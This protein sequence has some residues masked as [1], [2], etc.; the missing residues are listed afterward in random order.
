MNT[1]SI[2][3]DD[4]RRERV[5]SKPRLNGLDYLD[6]SDDQL[7]L[8]VYFL[9]KA[10]QHL[11]K[12]NVRISGGRRIDDIKVL[13]VDVERNEN[14]DQDDVMRVRLDKSG[15]FS[16]Y[17]LWLEHTHAYQPI[18][19][20]Y[21]HIDFSF[22]IDCPSDL[23][24]AAPTP[25]PPAVF[26]EP[27]INYLAKDYAS[28]RQLILDRL[29]VTMPEWRERH[30]PDLG[31]TLVELLA[32]V[33][34][35]LSYYQDAVATEAYLDTAR[36]RISVRR[37]ARLVD[38]LMHEGC[39][40]RA[41][42]HLEVT[43]ETVELNPRDIGFITGLNDQTGTATLPHEVFA[44]LPRHTY[45]TFVPLV[46]DDAANTV[47]R[48]SHNEIYFYTWGQ[49]EC[50]LQ[51]GTTNVTLLDCLPVTPQPDH[52][53]ASI[54]PERQR[55]LRLSPGDVLLF[56]EVIGPRTGKEADADLRHRQ[57]VRLTRVTK[58]VDPLDNTLLLEVEWSS[59]DALTFPLCI[60][61][62]SDAENKCVYLPRVSVARGN[63][64]LVQHGTWVSRDLGSV[65]VT[66]NP[67]RECLCVDEIG[68][69]LVLAKRF[70]PTITDMPLAFA[71]PYDPRTPAARVL[72]Q[73]P[74]KA[75]PVITLTSASTDPGAPARIDW[76]PQTDLLGSGPRDA[77][78]VM[79]ID[80]DGSAHLRF[81]DDDL[82]LQPEAGAQFEARYLLGNGTAGN[83][84]AES[85][86]HI[87]FGDSSTDAVAKVRNPLPAQGG[88]NPE[89]MAEVKL[90][91]PTAFRKIRQRAITPADCAEF[92]QQLPGVQR[93]AAVQRWT[94]SWYEMQVAVD[95]LGSETLSPEL[96]T[97]VETWLAPYRRIGMD[98]RVLQAAYVPLDI[99]VDVCVKADYLR[100]H[101]KAALLAAFGTRPGRDGTLG[102][103]HPDRLTF[104]TGVYLSQLVATAQA[105]D[106][107]ESVRVTRLRRQFAPE[108]DELANGV[109]P[110]GALEIARVDNDP[111]YPDNG[112]ITLI[113]SG[114]R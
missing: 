78:Y 38:Y 48:R 114:G 69:S 30:V 50:C 104:G 76:Q 44:Q 19:P 93:A 46:A 51:R 99:V 79:E 52:T 20:L 54:L 70:E 67:S 63:M 37:H 8:A 25:C 109:L 81:G 97:R 7:T 98:V 55:I 18:D 31:I 57:A 90:F 29:A 10:P 33:G 2:C 95:P 60:S 32:Y 28:F 1:T 47:L 15:D 75:R 58:T 80:D 74:R 11:S 87:V 26:E 72:Q 91:A 113:V 85:I 62:I 56:E 17:T 23:D 105:I 6:V 9:G 24:C 68:D 36:K 88:V 22:K 4:Q 92:A 64:M 40:A 53:G 110:L 83:V 66:V 12:D 13:S 34:D 89:S 59:E 107:V 45:E 39:H 82:G 61:A 27:V 41:F 96:R 112:Q 65:G 42:V 73:D 100:G 49:R 102:F 101:V 21:N 14:E 3:L 16:T 35:H 84:G 71:E 5:R 103:F 108:S 43:G 106:G 94:G 77:H 86:R 111:T